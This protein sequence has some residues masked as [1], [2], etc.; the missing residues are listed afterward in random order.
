MRISSTTLEDALREVAEWHAAETVE[1]LAKQACGSLA[2]LIPSDGVGWNEVD[3]VASTVRIAVF[4]GDYFD[5]SRMEVLDRLIHENPIVRHVSNT[6]DT[7]SWAFSDLVSTR[8]YHRLE[9]Y[10]DFYGP[11]GVEDQLAVIVEVDDSAIVGIALNRGAR[12][13][14]SEH[15]ALLDVLR[16][17]LEAAY[18]SLLLRQEALERLSR[19]ERALEDSGR[20]IVLLDGHGRVADGTPGALAALAHWFG[21]RAPAPGDYSNGA[22]KL[23]VRRAG[24]PRT[25]LVDEERARPAAE[26]ARTLG[27]TVRELEVVE[28]GGRGWSD[29]AIARALEI[30]PRTV[31]KHFSNAF[32]KLGVHSRGEAALV[33]KQ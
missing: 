12:T 18:R 16:P 19:L 7:G 1:S 10:N 8:D 11:L 30:S 2:R 28:L 15:R 9:L 31:Q 4:P 17:H 20:G 25:L 6:G 22:D 13:F 27:L 23:T 24:D 5:G 14:T 33:V 3:L 29:A 21:D 26:R 32:E